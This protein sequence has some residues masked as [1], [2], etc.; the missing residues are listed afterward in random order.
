MRLFFTPVLALFLLLCGLPA[1]PASAGDEADP[2]K[3]T[4]YGMFRQAPE[5][6][7]VFVNAEEPDAVYVPFDPASI[8][9]DVLGVK[10]QVRGEIRDTFIRQGKT[11][12]ILAVT[13]I[14]PMTAEYGATTV[15]TGKHF[16][17]PG[18][19]PAE[20]HAYH[21]RTC[22]LYDRYAVVETLASYSD[23]H[24]L[25]VLTHAPGEDRDAVCEGLKGRPLFEIPNGGD[26]AFAGLAGDTLF[27]QNGPAA[28][29][30]GLMAVNLA[31]Q[32]QILDATVI[33]G[34]ALDKGVLRYQELVPPP[35]AQKTCP[36]GQS[37][38]RPMALDLKT[39]AAREAG[40][41]AC[42]P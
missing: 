31:A 23:G 41:A 5:G 11:Y 8:M 13:D 21:N 38:I 14:R 24:T 10:V 32:K 6:G 22:Y 3:T 9:T 19:D 1:D 42:R 37:A 36:A 27:V 20:I 7:V 29:V 2:K 17:L 40:K 15:A 30:H 26:F 16:G 12:R 39:G 18:S 34:A 4:L 35:G 28:A 25:R 33:P